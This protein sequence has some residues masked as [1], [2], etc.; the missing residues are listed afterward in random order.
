MKLFQVVQLAPASK[1][2]PEIHDGDQPLFHRSIA[3][4][5]RVTC[6]P[7]V[8]RG[9]SSIPLIKGAMVS[10]RSISTST[11]PVYLV[12]LWRLILSQVRF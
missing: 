10:I 3:S 7:V 12:V 1:E 5:V 6:P 4:T 8:V 2:Y 9:S 11:I